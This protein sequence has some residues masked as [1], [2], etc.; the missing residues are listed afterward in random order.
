MS[1]QHVLYI[2]EHE[3][4]LQKWIVAKI[5]LADRE[6]IGR[7]PVSINPAQQFGR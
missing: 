7:A 2:T 6:I 4:P 3:R 5:D 1:Q